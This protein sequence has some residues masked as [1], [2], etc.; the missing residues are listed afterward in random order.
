MIDQVKRKALSTRTRLLEAARHLFW[1]K[2]FAATGMA[3]LLDRAQANSG[4]FYHFF[5]SKESLL[6][7][8][9]DSYLEGLHPVIVQPAEAAFADPLDRIFGILQGYRDR[10]VAT[11]R[12]YGCP[13]GRLAL[14]IEAENLPAHSRI[15]AN[16]SAWTG[17]IRRFLEEARERFPPGTDLDGL[18]LFVLTTMEGGV[19]QSR[20]YRKIEPFDRSVAHLRNYFEYLQKEK[21]LET[22]T[23][24]GGAA[25]RSTSIRRGS[26][27]SAG[28]SHSPGKTRKGPQA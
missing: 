28:K 9:L 13:I 16:F 6:L 7:A 2:G 17:A 19:M 18:A 3:E 26:A 14:E 4:S 21:T 12:R 15:A 22:S 10:L 5:D 24:S 1:E 11:G 20:S 27:G 25:G 8:L 23:R